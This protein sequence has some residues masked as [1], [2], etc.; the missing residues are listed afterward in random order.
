LKIIGLQHLTHFSIVFHGTHKIN[1]PSIQ[2]SGFLIPGPATG[3]E[4]VNG[5]THGNGIYLGT[6]PKISD[7]YTCG[8]KMFVCA[9]LDDPGSV[10]IYKRMYVATK[11]EVVLPWYIV[12]YEL[13][14]RE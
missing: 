3:I 9:L 14:E 7:A 4:H 12:H 11:P 2:T 5:A 1:I 10:K 13:K 8:N 6:S